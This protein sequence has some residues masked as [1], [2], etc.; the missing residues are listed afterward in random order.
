MTPLQFA[1]EQCAN[2]ERDGSCAGIWI[3]DDGRLSMFGRKPK[4]VVAAGEKCKYF[5]ETVLPMDI[6]PCNAVNVIR[7]KEQQEAVSLYYTSAPQ[8]SRESGRLCP[9]CGKREFTPPK[10]MCENCAKASVRESKRN[11]AKGAV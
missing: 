6:E 4:C 5:E 8:S 3:H 7:R 10:R 1:K 11:Y 9:R 2:Y